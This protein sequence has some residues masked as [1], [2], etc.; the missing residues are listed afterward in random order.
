MT[1]N[2][3]RR[4]FIICALFVIVF[5]FIRLLLVIFQGNRGN[6]TVH[7]KCL[8]Y[9]VISGKLKATP[10]NNG[11]L[12]TGDNSLIIFCIMSPL[13]GFLY[14]FFAK[15]NKPA[16]N[17]G[18]AWNR[19]NKNQDEYEDITE[20]KKLKLFRYQFELTKEIIRNER[21]LYAML[22]EE[23]VYCIDLD[24]CSTS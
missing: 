8:S 3:K 2:T 15:I 19:M 14:F 9:N 23:F 11:C 4:L 18:R 7:G 10:F 5:P 24:L 20:A 1:D 6:S 12:N 17:L 21:Q 16:R 13:C 22:D